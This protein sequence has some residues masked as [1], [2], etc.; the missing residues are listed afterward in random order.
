MKLIISA[1][2]HDTDNVFKVVGSKVKVTVSRS[3]TTFHENV[4]FQWKQ[5]V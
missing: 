1:G 2:P 4:L 5:T 3:L